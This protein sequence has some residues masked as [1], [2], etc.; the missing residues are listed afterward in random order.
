MSDFNQNPDESG[1]SQPKSLFAPIFGEEFGHHEMERFGLP[2]NYKSIDWSDAK[3]V[4]GWMH[5]CVSFVPTWTQELHRMVDASP[6]KSEKLRQ[7]CVTYCALLEGMAAHFRQ[8]L[9]DHDPKFALFQG[10]D[11]AP[12]WFDEAFPQDKEALRLDAI[13]DAVRKWALPDET[14]RSRFFYPNVFWDDFSH[15]AM[16]DYN[17]PFYYADIDWYDPENARRWLKFI[18]WFWP[19]VHQKLVEVALE[20]EQPERAMPQEMADKISAL[21]QTQLEILF[22]QNDTEDLSD[23]TP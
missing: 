20:K 16:S 6:N 11:E 15:P 1:K 9:H 3:Q 7:N 17:L 23:I 12:S 21:F 2:P 13:G 10:L 4:A 8:F 18:L 5:F 22:P 14:G 19:H